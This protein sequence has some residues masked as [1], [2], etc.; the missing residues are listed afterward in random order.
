MSLPDVPDEVWQFIA[1][2]IDTVPHLEALLLLWENQNS[3][4]SEDE[5]AARIYVS[6]DAAAGILQALQRRQ[7]VSVEAGPPPRYRYNPAGDASSLMPRVVVAYRRHLV[8]IA[9]FIH[10]GASSSV[11]EFARAFDLK[12]K[13]R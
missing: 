1:E 13:D 2:K 11:R 3:V 9:T 6:R 12:K 4:W 7:L 8:P 5:I 10:T